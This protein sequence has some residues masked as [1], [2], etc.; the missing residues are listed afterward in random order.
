MVVNNEILKIYNEV[1]NERKRL[2]SDSS[3]SLE[4]KNETIKSFIKK[5]QNNYIKKHSDYFK[6]TIYEQELSEL[7]SYLDGLKNGLRDKK[8]KYDMLYKAIAIYNSDRPDALKLLYL[9]Q[10]IDFNEFSKA[11]GPFL[12]TCMN[13]SII[14][15]AYEVYRFMDTYKKDVTILMVDNKEFKDDINSFYSLLKNGS[16][17]SEIKEARNNFITKYQ[18]YFDSSEYKKKVEWLKMFLN[19]NAPKMVNNLNKMPLLIA[20]YNNN[21]SVHEKINQISK[22]ISPIKLIKLLVPYAVTFYDN[23]FIKEAMKVYFFVKEHENEFD[24][25][26]KNVLYLEHLE[27]ETKRLFPI[28]DYAYSVIN[29]YVMNDDCLSISDYIKQLD[30]NVTLFDDCI[31]ACSIFNYDLYQKFNEEKKKRDIFVINNEQE[32]IHDLINGIKTGYLSDGTK[33]TVLEFLKRIPYKLVVDCDP[34]DYINYFCFYLKK[35]VESDG[36]SIISSYMRKN[37]ISNLSLREIDVE[38]ELSYHV[39]DNN[40]I[41]NEIHDYIIKYMQYYDYPLIRGIYHLLLKKYLAD[42]LEISAEIK[43][44]HIKVKSILIP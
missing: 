41:T 32:V 28:K 9:K 3:L 42:E 7:K 33:L 1:E 8:S 30:I 12:V 38:W 25:V 17:K 4:N 24:L 27:S 26:K 5:I 13:N 20:I 22:A 15:K 43:N 39:I 16:N 40:V 44:Y 10:I 11:I 18:Y 14:K 37:K 19:P 6:S 21:L 36:I 29:Y 31:E 2:D 34:E 23:S 35:I